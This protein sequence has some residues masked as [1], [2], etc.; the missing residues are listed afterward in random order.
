MSLHP[1]PLTPIN[2]G[3]VETFASPNVT[4]S[5]AY[6]YLKL[7]FAHIHEY[8][9]KP[10][11][12]HLFRKGFLFHRQENEEILQKAKRN[13]KKKK[14]KKIFIHLDPIETRVKDA[15]QQLTNDTMM[16]SDMFYYIYILRQ[17]GVGFYRT[18]A[19]SPSRP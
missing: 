6:Y 19:F 4:F 15:E 5:N 12:G 7:I 9:I 18:W 10:Y 14:S 8:F 17:A 1:Q 11:D 16:T 2:K 3:L 13:L